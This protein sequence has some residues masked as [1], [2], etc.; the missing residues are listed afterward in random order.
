[1][2]AHPEH[3]ELVDIE[4]IKVLKA[5]YFRFVDTKQWDDLV[6]LFTSDAQFEYPALGKFTSASAAV[7][8]IRSVLHTSSTVHHGHMPEI[9]LTG[10]DEATGVWAMYDYVVPTDDEPAAPVG[11]P[12]WVP[13]RRQGFGHY[14]E[15][16]R[17][18]ADGWRISS[19]Q[20]VRLRKESLS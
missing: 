6:E 18:E 14:L 12:G 16:Y 9:A 11:N 8:A 1:V 10:P 15:T 2:L 4:A 19:L 3:Q 5:R 13:G 7:A 17:R 20:L